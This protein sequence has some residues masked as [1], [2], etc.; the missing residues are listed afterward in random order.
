MGT[1]KALLPISGETLA[2][3]TARVL[4]EGGCAPVALV[5][6]QPALVELG[7][8]VITE[9]PGAHHP[10]RG[11]AAALRSIQGPLALFAPCD[12]PGLTPADIRALIAHGGP[13][14]A[15]TGDRRNPLLSV[16]PRALA[17]PAAAAARD[18][19]GI[20]R[21]VSDL[22]LIP[23]GR[24]AGWN[25]NT[26]IDYAR[27]VAPP[28]PQGA[29]AMT[30]SRKLTC[31][32][33]EGG[34]WSADDAP[35]ADREDLL[36]EVVSSAAESSTVKRVLA[37]QALAGD[38][39]LTILVG[40]SPDVVSPAV[41][42]VLRSLSERPLPGIGEALRRNL[43]G[44]LGA[45]A[46]LVDVSA[47]MIG[48]RPA[49]ALPADDTLIAAAWHEILAP[50]LETPPIETP[51]AP[52]RPQPVPEPV[53]PP[54]DPA[55][56]R[57]V[58]ETGWMEIAWTSTAPGAD[59]EPGTRAGWQGGLQRMG[60]GIDRSAW[61]SLPESL[62]EIPGAREVLEMAGERARVVL[63]DGSIS[64]AFGYPDL[65]R[66]GAK[67][68]LIRD[69]LPWPEVVALHRHPRRV[70]VAAGNRLGVLPATIAQAATERG[71]PQPPE[72]TLFAADTHGLYLLRGGRVIRWN[73]R[74]ERDTGTPKQAL[75]SLL[76]SWS[77][78]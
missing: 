44:T 18:G 55:L 50:L 54:T 53:E 69:D 68:L 64:V 37:R 62:A 39:D 17:D 71:F 28:P 38:G 63:E 77:S 41:R 47:G 43:A 14:V 49:V 40:P 36:C 72:G 5:G 12:L 76:L 35:W 65:R 73:G 3:R 34:D 26:P 33:L 2:A 6:N 10:G 4:A 13:C 9:L 57:S 15:I 23:V 31:V 30:T 61:P 1:D 21:L 22:P 59:P 60:G 32:I 11:L 42:A 16:L 58:T 29:G 46:T 48:G 56:P 70:G 25:V 20:W 51:T 27:R 78:R 66:P 24:F 67:V 75:A 45:H 74:K 52:I 19:A 7:W 8:P